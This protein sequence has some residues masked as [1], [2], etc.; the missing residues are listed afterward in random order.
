MAGSEKANVIC[1][2]IIEL[3]L[4]RSYQIKCKDNKKLAGVPFMLIVIA[5]EK[6]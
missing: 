1:T 3:K 6:K 4:A 5:E 2:K